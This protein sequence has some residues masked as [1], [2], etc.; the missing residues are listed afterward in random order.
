M[1]STK[2]FIAGSLAIPPDWEQ[3]VSVTLAMPAEKMP[4]MRPGKA[5]QTT[6]PQP[7]LV[8][9]LA[10]NALELDEA[11]DLFMQSLTSSIPGLSRQ[12]RE[13][14]VF[15]DGKKGRSNLVS[16]AL[17]G[18]SISQQHI[19]RKAGDQLVHLCATSLSKQSKDLQKLVDTA[20]TYQVPV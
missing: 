4:I 10:P 11:L 12:E 1:S 9:T 6:G 2:N 13:D 20:R 7:N 8:V 18:Q 5:G 3:K 19:V 15:A 17:E 16:F 14:F